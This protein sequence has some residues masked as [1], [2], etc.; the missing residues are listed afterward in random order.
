MNNPFTLISFRRREK[1]FF[2]FEI[3]LILNAVCV[4]QTAQISDFGFQPFDFS[5]QIFHLP[6]LLWESLRR[7]CKHM[8]PIKPISICS[9]FSTM[10]VYRLSEQSY[11]FSRTIT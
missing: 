1:L 4:Q 7:W 10:S 2:I 11:L 8:S 3:G 9:A 6:Y 5:L